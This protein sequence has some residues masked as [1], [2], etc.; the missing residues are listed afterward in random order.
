M[1]RLISLKVK[2]AFFHFQKPCQGTL[3]RLDKFGKS[4]SS[5]PGH[6]QVYWCTVDCAPMESESSLNSNNLSS[7]N[8]SKQFIHYTLDASYHF[9]VIWRPI[10]GYTLGKMKLFVDRA[11]VNSSVEFDVVLKFERRRKGALGVV[12]FERTLENPDKNY[13]KSVWRRKI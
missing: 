12:T 10:R 4:S 2:F 13:E 5:C 3:K 6:P 7:S 1:F 9:N 11:L 8:K